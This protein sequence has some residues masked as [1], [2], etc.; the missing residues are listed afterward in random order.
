MTSVRAGLE[1]RLARLRRMGL[2][3]VVHIHPDTLLRIVRATL[4][5]AVAWEVASLMNSS[6]PVLAS[7]GAVL[8]VQ[9]TVRAT[10]AR[11]I[12]LTIGVSVG[13]AIAVLVGNA[14]GL[15]WWSIGL[16]VLGGLMIGELL[17]LG[18]F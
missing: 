14:V 12:Q 11:T 8:V 5:A 7:L 18:A 4:A 16:V 9:V 2:R 3:G 1:S 17:R 10:L 15:H 13:L 6:R